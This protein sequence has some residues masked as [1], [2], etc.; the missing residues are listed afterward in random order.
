MI[1]P[2]SLLSHS[3]CW[4]MQVSHGA[5]QFMVYEELKSV[6][7]GWGNSHAHS[8]QREITSPEI[9]GIGALSKLAATVITYPSQVLDHHA[10]NARR[11]LGAI[12]T[13]A[14]WHAKQILGMC[15]RCVQPDCSQVCSIMSAVVLWACAGGQVAAP[16]EDAAPRN[17][18]QERHGRPAYHTATGR[19]ARPIQGYRPKC[20]ARC[21]T[22]CA[23]LPC[24]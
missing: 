21:A 23:D 16:A 14:S 9:M 20:A 10:S 15:K 24:I 1:W 6:A 7:G 5:I 22:V 12:A 18:L 13:H 3:M 17:T 8:R 19:L 11:S 2:K 4:A